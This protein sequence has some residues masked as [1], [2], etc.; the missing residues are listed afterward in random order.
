MKIVDTFTSQAFKTTKNYNCRA[1]CEKNFFAF[2]VYYPPLA[3]ADAAASFAAFCP[4][5]L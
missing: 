5:S 1:H 2:L 3:L 4:P